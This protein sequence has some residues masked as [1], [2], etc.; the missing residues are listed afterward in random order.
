MSRKGDAMLSVA[1]GFG[2]GWPEYYKWSEPLSWRE[3]LEFNPRVGA[4][5]YCLAGPNLPI[6]LFTRNMEFQD[7]QS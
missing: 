5:V 3:I 7:S 6:Q 4:L 2:R 1:D